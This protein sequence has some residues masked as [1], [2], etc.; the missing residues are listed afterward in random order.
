MY[1]ERY[2][3]RIEENVPSNKVRV[4]ESLTELERVLLVQGQELMK[5]S[6]QFCNGLNL[7]HPTMQV[8]S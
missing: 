2:N 1:Q 8:L 3:V 4:S 5:E 6:I 7:R